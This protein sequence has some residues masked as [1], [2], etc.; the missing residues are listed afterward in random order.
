MTPRCVS[1]DHWDCG[2]AKRD[3]QEKGICR[4][5]GIEIRGHECCE[6][7]TALQKMRGRLITDAFKDK[8]LVAQRIEIEVSD[9]A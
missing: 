1:C 9:E 7:H 3:W 4:H 5:I 2:N 6:G 8:S